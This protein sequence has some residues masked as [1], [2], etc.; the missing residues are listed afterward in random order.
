MRIRTSPLVVGALLAGTLAS[1]VLAQADSA[2]RTSTTR[3]PISKSE[4]P[5]VDTV[6][7]T[8]TDTVTRTI[9][10]RVHDTVRVVRRD[11]VRT[12]AGVVAPR[13]IRQIG[14]FYIGGSAGAAV[15]TGDN[16]T[17]W[18]S[19]GWRIE[20]PMGW[21]PLFF[22]LGG[23][24]NFGYSQFGKRG[25]FDQAF[26]TPEIFS[27]DGNAKLRYPVKSP[28][29]RRYQVYALGGVTYNAFRSIAQLDE[30]TGL[31]TI[32]DSTGTS[33]E[34][35]FGFPS[36]VDNS[37]HSAWGWNAGGGFQ[38]GWKHTN[39]FIESRY[40]HFSHNGI[41]LSQVPIV[42]GASW[43]GTDWW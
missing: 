41:G 30:N 24:L 3:I 17:N 15:P 4:P 28:W 2:R 20:V 13:R 18:Q 27:I 19:T 33:T 22:P 1:T 35:N 11:T 36:N 16:F 31:V 37:W 8:R 14:G 29:M 7:L 39:V 26:S 43:I 9:T 23:R 25:V 6:I 21:D 32:G 40:T 5:R 42:I 38:M 34:V 10:R 12:A